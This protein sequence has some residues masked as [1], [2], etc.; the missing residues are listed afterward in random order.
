MKQLFKILPFL[1]C[2]GLLA[3]VPAVRVFRKE[4]TKQVLAVVK[5]LLV[6][7]ALQGQSSI[8][9]NKMPV[10]LFDS[11]QVQNDTVFVYRSWETTVWVLSGEETHKYVDRLIYAYD[12]RQKQIV[13]VRREEA[14]K[15]LVERERMEKYYETKWIWKQ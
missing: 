11:V 7:I 13:F 15:E 3:F 8:F 5:L 12:R 6:V 1:L 2:A 10:F 14:Q 4:N 9:E